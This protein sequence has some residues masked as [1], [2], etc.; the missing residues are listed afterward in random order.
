M[1]CHVESCKEDA[2]YFHT[3][4]ITPLESLEIFSSKFGIK[5]PLCTIHAVISQSSEDTIITIEPVSNA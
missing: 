2:R 3:Q 1:K 4:M 5:V